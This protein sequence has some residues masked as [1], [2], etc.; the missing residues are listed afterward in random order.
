MF[1]VRHTT[2]VK[3]RT[4]RPQ[5]GL[6]RPRSFLLR[7]LLSFGRQ[8][9]GAARCPGSVEIDDRPSRRILARCPKRARQRASLVISLAG[10]QCEALDPLNA[11]NRCSL[12]YTAEPA[13]R[14]RDRLEL[15][16]L[17]SYAL[18]ARWSVGRRQGQRQCLYSWQCSTRRALHGRLVERPCKA[19]DQNAH[20]GERA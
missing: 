14:R 18:T 1:Q 7:R 5:G 15:T 6:S 12:L 9:G 11:C 17:R 2:P 16:T 19:E 10:P 20:R 8:R 4:A 13:P 3:P